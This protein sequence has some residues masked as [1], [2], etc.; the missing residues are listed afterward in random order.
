M[1]GEG[2]REPD[3]PRAQRIAVVVVSM[4]L[5]AGWQ[6]VAVI[7]LRIMAGFMALDT[8]RCST[9]SSRASC[10]AG[11]MDL[12]VLLPIVGGAVGLLVGVVGGAVAVDQH[13][14]PYSWIA[15]AWAL[16]L[17]GCVAAVVILNT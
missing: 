15:L 8:G 1:T 14:R 12:V 10:S 7:V 16:A 9:D 5:L 2:M 3:S 11:T 17:A 13:R 4:V 6:A